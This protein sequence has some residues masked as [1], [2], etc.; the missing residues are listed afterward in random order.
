VKR[1]FCG[2]G[3][4]LSRCSDS[5]WSGRSEDRITVG[6]KFSASRHTGPGPSQSPITVATGSF[7]EVTWP[8][9]DVNHPLPSSRE[10]KEIVE[11]HFSHT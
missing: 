10:V 4:K 2:P 9:R 11:V 5:L 3:G 8:E 1:F 7:P 6:I